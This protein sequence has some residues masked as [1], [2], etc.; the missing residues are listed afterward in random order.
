MLYYRIRNRPPLAGSREKAEKTKAEE[1]KHDN[2]GGMDCES[3]STC[4]TQR[5]FTSQ[6]WVES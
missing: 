1:T 6:H 5:G 4:Q 3:W 2:D